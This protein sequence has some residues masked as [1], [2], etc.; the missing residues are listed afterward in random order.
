MVICYDDVN[1]FCGS[2]WIFLCRSFV[3]RSLT[4]ICIDSL[5]N[6]LHISFLIRCLLLWGLSFMA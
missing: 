6:S 2:S 1:F 5:R 3:A 4:C